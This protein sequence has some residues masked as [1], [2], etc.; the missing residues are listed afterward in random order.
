MPSVLTSLSPCENCKFEI[1]LAQLQD[2]FSDKNKWIEKMGRRMPAYYD[3]KPTFTVKDIAE[4]SPC[5]DPANFVW[6]SITQDALT[7]NFSMSAHQSIADLINDKSGQDS[8]WILETMRL[9]IILRSPLLHVL[10]VF[11]AGQKFR[12]N[13]FENDCTKLCWP[14]DGLWPVFMAILYELKNQNPTMW[15][16]SV[17]T[18]GIPPVL[19]NKK[20]Q[21]FDPSEEPWFE[22]HLILQGNEEDTTALREAAIPG[23]PLTITDARNDIR[24][25]HIYWNKT[26]WEMFNADTDVKPDALINQTLRSALAT[27]MQKFSTFRE[28][29]YAAM[30]FDLGSDATNE[31]SDGPDELR[32]TI[33][34]DNA[35]WQFMSQRGRALCEFDRQ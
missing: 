15:E 24:R 30:L 16:K 12:P 1:N 29:L 21:D 20:H 4:V 14:I 18:F 10:S 25:V 19:F 31:C 32:N 26:V 27:D 11:K 3:W 35:L 7:V 28:R 8:S 2:N 17:W 33:Y 22:N 23:E 13:L 6:G 5:R 34:R 9:F